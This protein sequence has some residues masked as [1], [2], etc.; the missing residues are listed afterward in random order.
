[1]I[2]K[3][4]VFLESFCISDNSNRAGVFLGRQ[5]LS[6]RSG[7]EDKQA[8][9]FPSLSWFLSLIRLEKVL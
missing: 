1:L 6:V 9:S 2:E 5:Q 3:L 8:E 7:I 4:D